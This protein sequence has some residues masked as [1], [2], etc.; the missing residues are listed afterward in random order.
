[1][2]VWED[3]ISSS[4]ESV[5][6]S[7]SI[8]NSGENCENENWKKEVKSQ[9]NNNTFFCS[10]PLSSLPIDQHYQSQPT[11]LP[12]NIGKKGK[13]EKQR[14]KRKKGNTKKKATSVALDRQLKGRA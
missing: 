7:F 5:P 10:Y 2:T 6:Y 13:E 8:P 9:A 3:R 12:P 4:N 1:M 11:Q 14:E